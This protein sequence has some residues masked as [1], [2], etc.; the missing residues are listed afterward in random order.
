MTDVKEYRRRVD[1][2]ERELAD[3]RASL[4]EEERWV[5]VTSSGARWVG[6]SWDEA[7]GCIESHPAGGT[8]SDGTTWDGVTH[9]ERETRLTS[10]WVVTP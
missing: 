3:L 7:L 2:L 10:E 1:E 4:A 9:I 5:P 6:R 8:Y